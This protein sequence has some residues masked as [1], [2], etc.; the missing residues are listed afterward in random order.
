MEVKLISNDSEIILPKSFACPICGMDIYVSEVS[1]WE[2]DDDGNWKAQAVKIDCVSD[3]DFTGDH[4]SEAINGHL[5]S[6]WRMPY[7]D[8]LPLEGIV[9]EWV[10]EHYSWDLS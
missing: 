2:Q 10:N 6:H 9:T 8:W 7:V 5:Q 1:E 3:P 4:S